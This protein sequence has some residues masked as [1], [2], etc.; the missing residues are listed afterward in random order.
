[1]AKFFLFFSLALVIYMFSSGLVCE[2]C[3][4]SIL[5]RIVQCMSV[6]T[7]SIFNRTKAVIFIDMD[8]VRG[9]KEKTHH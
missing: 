5:S 9:L 6:M 2:K 1:M 4:K 3:L 8:K 7:I